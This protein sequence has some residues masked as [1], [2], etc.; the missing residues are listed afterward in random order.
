MEENLK[1]SAGTVLPANWRLNW[2]TII[3][4]QFASN[5]TSMIVMYSL[6]WYITDQYMSARYMSLFALFGILPQAIFSL[7]IGP[8]IDRYNKK[9]LLIVPDIVVALAAIVLSIVGNSL[10]EFPIVWILIVIFIRSL[11]STFQG[12][13]LAS[14][15]P[16]QVPNQEINR[17]NG[18]RGLVMNS[19]MIIAPAISIVMYQYMSLHLIILFDVIGAAIASLTIFFAQIPKIN[20]QTDSKNISFVSD[21][22]EGLYSIRSQK[23][24]WYFTIFNALIW[25]ATS[26]GSSLYPLLTTQHFNSD[27]GHAS[28]VESAWSI[29][30]VI[31]S[32]IFASVKHWKNRMIPIGIAA[33]AV[34][35]LMFAG[36]ILPGNMF[37]F[38]F[39]VVI[40]LLASI[41]YPAMTDLFY[42]ITQEQF[43]ID[44]LGRVFSVTS[45]F[46][47]LASVLGLLLFGPLADLIG[48]S[49]LFFWSGLVALLITF[50]AM[51][52]KPIRNLDAKD[53]PDDDNHQM[54]GGNIDHHHH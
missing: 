15:I 30:A 11:A 7:F 18:M 24:I 33:V 36:G 17:A 42:A 16:T 43:K 26:A 25:M 8:L 5:L 28:I 46:T 27:L 10:G 49:Q 50:I 35:A 40:N 32:L 47:S 45:A 3:I 6:M 21:F 12:P 19:T 53:H 23:G 2:F 29:G 44:Q 14:V 4:G 34:S 13:T 48:I 22:K 51:T 37:G 1:S 39:F 52:I 54:V 31:G 20:N 9:F 41:M 38:W